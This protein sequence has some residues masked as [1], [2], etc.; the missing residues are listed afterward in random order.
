MKRKLAVLAVVS[1][2][3]LFTLPQA[4][5]ES[6]RIYGKV[7][8]QQDKVYE[9]RIRW[10]NQETFWDDILDAEKYSSYVRESEQRRKRKEIE[11][12][13]IKISWTEDAGEDGDRRFGIR[14]G[15]LRSIQR[16]S[17]KSAILE[18]KDGTRIRVSSSGTD[19][20]SSNRG[21]VISDQD[22]GRVTVEW[23]DFEKAIFSQE[24]AD[25]AKAREDWR[26]C[27]TVTTWDGQQFRGFIMWDNDESL[28]SDVL[29]GECRGEDMEIPFSRILAIGRKS[30]KSATVELTNGKQFRLRDS[31]DVNDENRGIVVEVPHLGK[32]TMDWADFDKA[33]FEKPAPGDL[34]GYDYFD[35]GEP[36]YGTVWDDLGEKYQGQI[37]WDDDETMSY[38]FLDGE[39][40]DISVMIEFSDIQS[41][42]RHS[43]SS[44][45]VKLK[46]G[47]ILKLKGTCDV[48]EGNR[49][50]FI[51]EDG[52]V[53]RLDWDEFDRVE[54]G[55][56]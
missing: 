48:D 5:G 7:Y 44:A 13:G 16:R 36:L 39:L 35:A 33:E 26:L 56:P 15:R 49:G 47:E 41:I 37:R 8:T 31:N 12:L 17:K 28:S 40:D 9:G 22:V 21:I 3:L 53:V 30:S 25:E 20:G 54:F 52:E 29:D 55:R 14:M 4:H 10:D 1:A 38:E 43:S 34:R 46:S 6:G 11:I 23:S 50:I 51:E 42:Q 24:P 32:V 19:I 18:L 2:V 27:G 45:R